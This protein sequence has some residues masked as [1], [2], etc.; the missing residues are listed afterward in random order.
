LKMARQVAA[1]EM[2]SAGVYR[3]THERGVPFLSI[4]GISDVVGLK[5]EPAWTGYACHSAASFLRAFLR[6]R[7]TEPIG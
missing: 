5:R 4:R 2:E 7:P 6:T 1:V 3:A